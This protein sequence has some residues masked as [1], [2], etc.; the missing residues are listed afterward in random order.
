MDMARNLDILQPE[1]LICSS[2]G[3][4]RIGD[5][6]HPWQ[7]VIHFQRKKVYKKDPIAEAL[8]IGINVYSEMNQI[9]DDIYDF[10]E[11]DF[12]YYNLIKCRRNNVKAVSFQKE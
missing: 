1:Q 9:R 2:C 8:H 4:V 12:V 6:N 11:P 3:T 10:I 7:E 5:L